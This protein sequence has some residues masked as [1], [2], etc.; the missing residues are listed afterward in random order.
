MY[1]IAIVEDE[2]E[3]IETTKG[4]IRRFEAESGERFEVSCYTDG[5]EITAD[6]RA[7]Y[8]IIF[9]DVKMKRMDGMETAKYIRT[10]DRD[11]I[12]IFITNMAQYAIKGYAVDALDFL[13]KPL[14]YFAFAE[15]LRRSVERLKARKTAYLLLPIENGVRKMDVSQVY[16]IESFKHQMI[17]HTKEGE[18]TLSETMRELEG[19]LA[20]S[21]FFRCNNCYLIN[22]MHVGGVKDSTV[23]VAGQE[24]AISRPRKKAF[25]EALVNYVGGHR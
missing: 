8:D 2:Q 24:L 13:L 22:L 5:D 15:Q 3:N 16:Y 6:Y 1:R 18:F 7:V 17:V 20:G 12:L 21:D 23:V 9:L 10:L 4:Y 25:M 19:R 14:S 11:V